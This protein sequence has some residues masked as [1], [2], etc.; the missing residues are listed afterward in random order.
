MWAA[1]ETALMALA[2][3]G[4]MYLLGWVLFGGPTDR[5]GPGGPRGWWP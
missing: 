5:G 1:M 4:G 2:L 3:L